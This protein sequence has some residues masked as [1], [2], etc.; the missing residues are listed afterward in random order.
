ML[1][2][3]LLYMH[4]RGRKMSESFERRASVPSHAVNVNWKLFF[5]AGV[6]SSAGATVGNPM[7][8]IKIR[9]QLDNELS[10]HKHA[11][12]KYNGMLRGL[13]T[14][15]YE[16]GFGAIWKGWSAAVLREMSFSAIRM[17]SYEPIKYQIGG[18][19]RANT[20]MTLKI[21][22]GAIAGAIGAVISN[23]T[24]VIKVQM[25][26]RVSTTRHASFQNV[27]RDIYRNGGV[28]SFYIASGPN[29]WRAVHATA[30]Q[31]PAYDHSKQTFLK[32]GIMVEGLPLHLTCSIIAGFA[33]AVATAPIDV[34]KTRLIKQSMD[35]SAKYRSPLDVVIKTVRTEGLR[36]L[37]KGFIPVWARIAPHTI[38]T[39]AVFEQLRL[40]AGISPL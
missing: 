9:L 20:P 10:Y 22:A 8:V 11:V 14:L 37:Y 25:Q 26:A 15:V 27:V 6:S 32:R 12:R 40:L 13:K 30:S 18:T 29:I 36:G 35:M 24:D 38:V 28:R 7:D 5:L 34:I 31:M 21:A 19:D 4:K 33:N 17:G 2:A 1:N 16:E 39:F 23:P 3:N